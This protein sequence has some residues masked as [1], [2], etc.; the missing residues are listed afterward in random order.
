MKKVFVLEELDC[1][2]C[3]AKMQA[4]IAKIDGV[5]LVSISFMLQR[6]EL[7]YN[8]AMEDAIFKAIKKAIAKVE[9]DTHIVGM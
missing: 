1:A 9:P 5:S 3:A 8:D 6:M 2:N 4:A 7:E